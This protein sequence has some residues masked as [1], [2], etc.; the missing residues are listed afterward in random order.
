MRL[1]TLPLALLLAAAAPALAQEK[2]SFPAGGETL[3]N[4]SATE[5]LEV[6][7][8]LL[9]ATLRVEQENADPKALQT[10]IN[11]A[12]KEAVG[13]AKAVPAVEIAT[14]HYYVYQQETMALPGS[15][16]K[17][18]K[19]AT[20]WRGAQSLTLTSATAE[21]VLKLAGALQDS[22]LVMENLYYALSP[23]KADEAKDNLMEAALTKVQ[24]RADRAAKALGKQ[25]AELAEVTVDAVDNMMPQPM[26]MRAMDMAGSMEKSAMPQ[27]EP[28][29]T[30]ITLTVSVR[31]QLK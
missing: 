10:S 15:R 26:M 29:E 7:Q 23:A 18:A 27:A 20:K 17:I 12:M 9:I 13:A 3:L 5:R 31:A 25:R 21:D 8:D 16:E 6:A 4:I 14:G 19:P 2:V 28:G 11:Q 24:A 22:G 30:E 1:L